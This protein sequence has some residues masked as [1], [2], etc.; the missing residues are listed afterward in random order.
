[1]PAQTDGR[2]RKYLQKRK[3]KKAEV[4]RVLA[5]VMENQAASSGDDR[6]KNDYHNEFFNTGRIGR[7]NA[8]PDILGYN[9]TT[10]TADLPDRL[11][12][13]TTNETQGA[14]ASTSTANTS[15]LPNRN[16]PSTSQAC[17]SSSSSTQPVDEAMN[18][19]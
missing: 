7:R 16:E 19:T 14:T 13:L 9:S 1:M 4:L 2:I 6:K 8:L 10:T 15:T 11:S 5:A 3:F 17:S 12:A 18:T